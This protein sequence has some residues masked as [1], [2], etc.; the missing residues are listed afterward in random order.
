MAWS[1]SNHRMAYISD[2]YLTVYAED[3]GTSFGLDTILLLKAEDYILTFD[4]RAVTGYH[5]ATGDDLD[6]SVYSSS[7][8]LSSMSTNAG[9][10][11]ASLSFTTDSNT[12]YIKFATTAGGGAGSKWLVWNVTCRT[13]LVR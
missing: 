13:T 12:T 1:T 9:V 2:G 11:A 6:V 7:G 4:C 3:G 8:G 5:G 10:T